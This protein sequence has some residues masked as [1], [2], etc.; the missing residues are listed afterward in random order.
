LA[1]TTLF[2]LD[3]DQRG[4]E[5]LKKHLLT[6]PPEQIG[7]TII[8]VEELIRGRLAQIRRASKPD[9]RVKAYY[10]LSKTFNFLNGFNVI[11]YD[12]SADFHFQTLFAQ[13]LRIGT[14]DL[15]I[16]A[17]ALNK[18]AILVTRNIRDFE[19]IPPLKIEDWSV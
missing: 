13:K 12:S 19:R 9:D 3:S 4:H 1:E 7:I 16:A 11:E 10:W 15:K 14:N 17:I 8:S 6:V 18:N 2:I 5:P